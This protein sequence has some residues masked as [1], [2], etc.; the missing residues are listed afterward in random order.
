MLGFYNKEKNS[1]RLV[2]V[3][4]TYNFIKIIKKEAQEDLVGLN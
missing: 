1:V 3:D 4:R 2:K